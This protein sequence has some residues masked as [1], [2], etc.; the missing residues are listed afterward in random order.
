LSSG[1][2]V[3]KERW[4]KKMTDV[5][6]VPIYSN[7]V[8]NE[9]LYG[10]TDIPQI[11][12][13]SVTITGRGTIG[14]AFLRKQPFFPIIRLISATPK[15]FLNVSYL[16]YCIQS[17]KFKVPKSGIPQLTIPM[18]SNIKIPIPPIEVQNKI[19][20]ILDQFTDLTTE[21]QAELTARKKQYEYYRDQLLTEFPNGVEYKK[22]GEIGKVSMCKRIMK[23]ETSPIGDVPFYKIGTFG[24]KAN[25]FI[26]KEKFEEYREKY[27]FP[28][29]GDI[30]ISASGTIGKMVIYNGEPSYYQDSN[31]VWIDNDESKV[32]N[33]WLYYCYKL[34]PWQ[35][36]T[37][38]T[39]SRL[40][41]DNIEKAKIPIPPIEVQ[42]KI[43]GILDRFDA[44]CND[45]CIGLPAEINARQKQYEYYRDQLLAFKEI[46]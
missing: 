4:S 41:N 39:I 44:L 17:I 42:N 24:G 26:T 45:L 10:Y 34:K 15:E 27:S 33:K 40:Y 20:H 5:Y 9:G 13:P 38:G 25:A 31:I 21:L 19:V 12:K 28:K 22:L 6:K 32:L 35:V 18:V 8:E 43:V 7:G 2:D 37:G 16:F 14:S 11:I 29:K 46:G 30:L 3:P 23:A 1:G 36:S